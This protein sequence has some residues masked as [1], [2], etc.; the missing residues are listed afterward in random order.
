MK[1]QNE[2]SIRI[3]KL[4]VEH[5]ILDIIKNE[6]SLKKSAGYDNISAVLIKWCAKAIAPVLTK[7]F[8]T[9]IELDKYPDVLKIAKSYCTIK[10][11]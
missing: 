11:G 4:V 8:N 9:F 2:Q 5:E 7:I 10:R 6:I 1:C 3:W